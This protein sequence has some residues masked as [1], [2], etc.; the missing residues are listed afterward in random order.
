VSFSTNRPCRVSLLADDENP[1]VLYDRPRAVYLRPGD[2]QTDYLERP[3][4][5]PFRPAGLV[6]RS[7]INVSP[8]GWSYAVIKYGTHAAP[9]AQPRV[10]KTCT[11]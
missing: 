9:I 7:L 11:G 2:R 1:T 6:A 8:V 4:S 5:T 10:R 3:I